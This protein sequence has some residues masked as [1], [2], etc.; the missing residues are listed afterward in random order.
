MRTVVTSD[1]LAEDGV[2]VE[3]RDYEAMVHGFANMLG[4]VDT[5]DEFF[6]YAGERLR[7]TFE[8]E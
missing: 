2:S 3:H 5:T 4:V 7:S 8:G 1:R 6:A